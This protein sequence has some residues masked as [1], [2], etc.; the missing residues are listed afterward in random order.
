MKLIIQIPCLNEE[1]TLPQT[2]GNLPTQIPG[3]DVIEYLIIDDG[4]T[5]RTVE[6][7]RELGVQHIVSH[8]TNK[9]LAA[10]FNTGLMACLERGADIIVNTD[11][12]NQ[13]PG[14]AIP[15][16]VQPLLDNQA[17]MVIGDRQT[18][19]IAHFSPV[20][21]RLQRVGSSVVR[22]VSGTE[23]PDAPSGFRALSREAAL[24]INAFTSYSYTLE[25]IIQASKKNLTLAWVPITVNPK[26][27]E[28]R[29]M[30]STISYVRRS[31]MTILHVFLLYEPLRTFSYLAVPFLALG[32]ILWGRFLVLMLMGEAARGSNIQSILVGAVAILIAF[33]VF[34]FGLVGHLVSINRQLH[35]ETLYQLKKM[36]FA[37]DK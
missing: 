6:V 15:A 25:T 3:V 14:D 10:A 7:A 18:H 23:V 24:R 28:S 37:D 33:L 13:Y 34:V 16:L 1:E 27:R 20:K 5:D 8:N 9:G 22:Y 21:K 31:G 35:E 36:R 32:A 11:G 12:D 26:T 2:V 17:D 30:K 4:S 29:L 19:K